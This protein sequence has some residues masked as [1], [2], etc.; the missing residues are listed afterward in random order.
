MKTQNYK[1]TQKIG[2]DGSL[3]NQIYG[4]NNT[5]PKVDEYCTFLKYTDRSVGIVREVKGD[6]IL[7]EDCTT[8]ADTNY[9]NDCGHQN[10]VHTPNG[11]VT[12]YVY[13]N[14]SWRSVSTYVDFTK[15]FI[16]DFNTNHPNE[17]IGLWL[18]K[19]DPDL[20]KKIYGGNI[21]PCNVIENVTQLRKTYNKVSIIFGL[22][23]YHYDWSF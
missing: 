5:Q 14:G 22:C 23:D 4:N 12:E 6:K 7:I 20:S 3:V 11:N 18:Y 9:K 2:I 10:W 8:V 19:N 21:H 16:K 13:K 1:Q 15:D 17:F